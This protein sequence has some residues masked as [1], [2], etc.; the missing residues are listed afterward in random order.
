MVPFLWDAVL[1]M[2]VFTFTTSPWIINFNSC[3]LCYF[4]STEYSF[5]LILFD[6][7]K[8]M[9][10]TKKFSIKIWFTNFFVGSQY[11]RISFYNILS[12]QECNSNYQFIQFFL[13]SYL[14]ENLHWHRFL[15]IFSSY[16][17]LMIYVFRIIIPY[18]RWKH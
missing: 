18:A 10:C 15:N 5:H 6:I 17:F 11:K 9:H 4:E 14:F 8:M 12:G 7:Y 13:K 2:Q 3:N 1:S 16:F